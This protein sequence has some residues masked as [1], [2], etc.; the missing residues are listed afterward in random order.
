MDEHVPL[1]IS[2]C[3]NV[4]VETEQALE[5]PGLMVLVA[6][7]EEDAQRAR[8]GEDEGAGHVP[9]HALLR[10]HRVASA[11]RTYLLLNI[12]LLTCF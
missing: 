9:Q 6:E 8:P 2:C 7:G 1:I 5:G 11:T 4:Y 10:L 3:L 12:F